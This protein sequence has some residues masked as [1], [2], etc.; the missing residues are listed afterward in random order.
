[1]TAMPPVIEKRWRI[2][3]FLLSHARENAVPCLLWDAFLIFP[4]A[5]FAVEN[6]ASQRAA[7]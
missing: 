3:H 7:L 1:M 5:R 2:P 4:F 6:A